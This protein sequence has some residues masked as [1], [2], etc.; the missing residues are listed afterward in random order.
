LGQ[1]KSRAGR[2]QEQVVS[3]SVFNKVTKPSVDTQLMDAAIKMGT[4][5]QE[6]ADQVTKKT[7]YKQLRVK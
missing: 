4:I 7:E 1:A 2:D 5:K 6:V 3:A